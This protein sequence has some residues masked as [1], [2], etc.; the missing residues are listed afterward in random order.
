VRDAQDQNR[1]FVV[2]ECDEIWEPADN[3]LANCCRL[4]PPRRPDRKRL[5]TFADTFQYRND[6]SD[7]VVAQPFLPFL[8]PKSG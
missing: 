3:G 6:R 8:V 5:W 1:V 4:L 7:E 2:F